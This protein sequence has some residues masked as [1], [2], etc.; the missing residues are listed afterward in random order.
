[1]NSRI[2][3]SSYQQNCWI[4]AHSF[5]HSVLAIHPQH[6]CS[7]PSLNVQSD[8]LLR[9][10]RVVLLRLSWRRRKAF[11]RWWQ[12]YLLC[13]VVDVRVW[14]LLYRPGC[15]CFAASVG[16][17]RELE[18]GYQPQWLVKMWLKNVQCVEMN[19]H[20]QKDELLFEG[21]FTARSSP[22]EAVT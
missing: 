13:E 18:S 16:A 21:Y 9:G 7:C 5:H 10:E 12:A 3:S 15:E 2:L 22:S 19:L 8:L 1:M 6:V 20:F 14:Q 4:R 11:L 17:S